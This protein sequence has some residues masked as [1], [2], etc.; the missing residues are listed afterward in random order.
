VVENLAVKDGAIQR[1]V[2][3]G[4]RLQVSALQLSQNGEGDLSAMG[5]CPASA[6]PDTAQTTGHPLV[7]ST[8]RALAIQLGQ[9]KRE[10]STTS[11][12]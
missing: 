9:Q 8:K 12:V 3:A 10:V 1:R 4:I 2:Q 7:T 6:P 5:G 11:F